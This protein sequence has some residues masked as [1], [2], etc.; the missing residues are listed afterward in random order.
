MSKSAT[1]VIEHLG[2]ELD[3]EEEDIVIEALVVAK[4]KKQSDFGTN[5]SS[6]VIGVSDTMDY[7]T[8]VGLLILAKDIVTQGED[9]D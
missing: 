4:V 1:D 9:D 8:Q 2:I 6:L 7:I 5:L 3:L